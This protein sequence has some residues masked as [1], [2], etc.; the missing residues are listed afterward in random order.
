[1]PFLNGINI[2]LINLVE[3]TFKESEIEDNE[4]V[5][6]IY[7]KTD[8]IILSSSFTKNKNKLFKYIQSNL[9]SLPFEKE[10]KK[11]LK[12]IEYYKKRLK[13]EVIENNIR[14]SFMN[15]FVKIFYKVYCNC[16]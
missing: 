6:L 2:S 4:E 14:D 15:F 8:E 10:L 1:M 12:N 13:K 7:V 3:Q 5:F 16:G 11:D 9:P